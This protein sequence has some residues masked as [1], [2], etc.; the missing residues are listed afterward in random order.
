MDRWEDDK[1]GWDICMIDKLKAVQI[2]TAKAIL[3]I[4]CKIHFNQ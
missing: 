3:E 2:D 1:K 4:L